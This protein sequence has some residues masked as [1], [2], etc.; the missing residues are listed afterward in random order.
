MTGMW[1]R[2]T[3]ALAAQV[4]HKKALTL[5][6][7]TLTGATI[8]IA[9]TSGASQ[10]TGRMVPL[11]DSA[12]QDSGGMGRVKQ[13]IHQPQH[14]CCVSRSPPVSHRRQPQKRQHP[15]W[16]TSHLQA[17]RTQLSSTLQRMN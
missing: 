7:T 2:R 10:G 3:R 14:P 9:G 5:P 4:L 6:I 17:A 12:S 11:G 15:P 8:L 13:G 1:M 16:V